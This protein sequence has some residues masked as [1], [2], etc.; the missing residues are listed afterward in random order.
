MKLR[1]TFNPKTDRFNLIFDDAIQT[2]FAEASRTIATCFQSGTYAFRS[3]TLDNELDDDLAQGSWLLSR[4][5][6]SHPR[7][8]DTDSDK[9]DSALC[10]VCW[11]MLSLHKA[12][13]SATSLER[14]LTLL[15]NVTLLFLPAYSLP[16]TTEILSRESTPVEAWADY[17]YLYSWNK[18]ELPFL[19]MTQA[20][21]LWLQLRSVT[22][23]EKDL[24]EL[25]DYLDASCCLFRMAMEVG[26]SPGNHAVAKRK[27]GK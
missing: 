24:K 17:E 3:H 26:D 20:H 10:L 2:T 1:A 18:S 22:H 6:A 27:Q 23:P 13:K 21:E 14:A 5:G 12:K 8:V 9:L 11:S 19:F 16:P 7:S 25:V 4:L 15:S